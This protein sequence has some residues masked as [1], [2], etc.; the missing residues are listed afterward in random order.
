MNAQS[1][2]DSL[3]DGDEI[4]LRELLGLLL[5]RKWLITSVTGVCFVLAV[6][7][8]LLASPVYEANAIV[9]VESKMP[10]I[11]GLPD[12]SSL[13]MGSGSTEATTEIALITSRTVIGNAVDDLHMDID[14]KPHRFPLI[15]NFIA[16]HFHPQGPTDV[17]K[18]WLGFSSDGWGGEELEIYRLDVPGA[19]LDAELTVQAGDKP[20]EYILY[21]DDGNQVLK[22]M[23]GANAQADGFRIQVEKLQANPGTKFAVTKSTRLSL[24]SK[25]QEDVKAAEQGKDSGIIQITYDNEDPDLAQGFLQHVAQAYVRQNVDRNSAQASQQLDFVKGQLPD[26]R[27]Q[28]D[29]AQSAMN[30]Y[31]T[32]SN[33]VDIDL[34]TKGLLDQEV[35]VETSIQQLKLKQAE[36]DRTYTP[37][38]PAYQA[39]MKQLADLQGRKDSFQK[40]VSSLPDAQ[41][42]LLK[43]NRDVQVNNQLYTALLSQAQQLD[44]ARAGTVGNVYIVDPAAVDTLH[45]V[46][47]KKPLIVLVGLLLGAFL[48]IGYVLLEKMLNRGIE[49]PAQIEE[50]GLP[51]YA[52]IPVSPAKELTETRGSSGLHVRKLR[53]LAINDPADLAVEAI[54]SLR[55]SLHFAMLEAK[56]NILT[57]SGP[58]PGVGKTFVTVNLAAVIA[59]SDQK[60]LVIDADMRKGTVHKVLGVSHANGLSDVLVGKLDP[61]KAI[62]QLDGLPNL[63][64]MTRGDIPP[65][66]SELLMH[67]RFTQVLQDLAKQYDIV[68]VDTPPILAV[69]DPAIV[70]QHAGANLLVMRFGVNQAR[71][72]A[73]TKK[74]F[75]QNGVTIKG[76]IFNAV[77]RRSAGYYSYGYY[78]YK[79]SKK[80]A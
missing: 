33:A 27:K 5:D 22:G 52:A 37:Q 14:V 8:A 50:L 57:I 70:A 2:T 40:Q 53:V 45:P 9:Q 66:P 72:I 68:I 36:M 80:D 4:D 1:K 61:A 12:L 17:A 18:P 42:E 44:V 25:L 30:A 28:L 35:A 54:R 16:R 39:L 65:N 59:Q 43:L 79:S 64:Y 56:N 23:V 38:H 11:P 3:L 76:A 29:M 26:V 24:L 32:K 10:S 63:H 74:R 51:V 7:Y 49:D 34:Q 69:T 62:Q 13:G 46:K 71:E 58:R 20:G 48:S 41:Q 67:P 6:A 73:L 31:Q 75:E 78:E 55:T 77:E 21:D 15:G 47:P 19:L 60:V